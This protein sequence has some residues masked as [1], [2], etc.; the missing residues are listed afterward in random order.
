MSAQKPRFLVAIERPD[1]VSRTLLRKAALL[2][3]NCGAS[4]ELFHVVSDLR[5]ETPSVTATKAEAADWRREV[6]AFRLRRLTRLAQSPVFADVRAECRVVWDSSACRAVVREAL[7]THADLVLA[8]THRHTVS[9][10]LTRESVDWE[11]I[12]QCPVPLL[13]AKA[14]GN[15][16]NSAV[17]TAVDPFHKRDKRATL[18]AKL[19]HLGRW[20]ARTLRGELHVFH[21]YMPLVPVQTMPMASPF[22]LVLMPPELERVHQQEVEREIARLTRS[23]HIPRARRHLLLGSVSS[24]LRKLA[25]RVRAGV[26]VMGAVSRS[27]IRRLLIGNTAEKVLD[28]IPCDVLVVKPTGFKSKF[29]L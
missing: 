18:D 21:A 22:P 1:H 4:V 3:Q 27:G 9:A 13:I 17:V 6:A 23:A 5:P 14:G 2:A 10:R 11:L 29:A 19:L 24:E 28:D 26:V 8:G 12:R 25:K 7:A 16:R 20:I 15:S